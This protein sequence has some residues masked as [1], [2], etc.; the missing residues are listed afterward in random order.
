MVRRTG[1]KWSQEELALLLYGK[2]L[3]LIGEKSAKLLY[4]KIKRLWMQNCGG[5][6]EAL[7]IALTKKINP[8][9]LLSN[10]EGLKVV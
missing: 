8:R 1:L 5:I 10:Y 3:P 9:R 6:S 4:E 2:I 7:K